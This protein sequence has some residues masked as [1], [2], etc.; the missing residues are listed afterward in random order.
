M[1]EKEVTIIMKYMKRY[2]KIFNQ[3]YK[4]YT[5]K[6][7]QFIQTVKLSQSQ[8]LTFSQEMY[9]QRDELKKEEEEMKLL[10]NENKEFFEFMKTFIIAQNDTKEMNENEIISKN[11]KRIKGEFIK[12]VLK[13]V[14]VKEYNSM[15]NQFEYYV[16]IKEMKQ[17]KEIINDIIMILNKNLKKMS[18]RY[19]ILPA[20]LSNSNTKIYSKC[21]ML[22]MKNC[23]LRREFIKQNIELLNEDQIYA[24]LPRP[25]I[26]F[27]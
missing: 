4:E 25:R 2:F 19:F 5:S 10:Y 13:L 16:M 3:I 18:L 9:S 22:L 26:K 23:H 6:R 24:L 27:L 21:K 11:E 14:D 20:I 15:I 17:H 8:N 12:L 1:K 7:S